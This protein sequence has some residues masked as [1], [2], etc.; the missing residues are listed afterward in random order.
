MPCSNCGNNVSSLG[1]SKS[2]GGLYIVTYTGD[3]DKISLIGEGTGVVYSFGKN[4]REFWA[5]FRDL[6]GLFADDKF[7]NDLR[8]KVQ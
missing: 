2:N 7:G 5:D 1:P 8:S 6:V 4:K 3:Q